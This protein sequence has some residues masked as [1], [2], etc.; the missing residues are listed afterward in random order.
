MLP[1]H[2]RA[3][4]TNEKVRLIIS[5]KYEVYIK[6]KSNV[7]CKK[8]VARQIHIPIIYISKLIHISVGKIPFCVPKVQLC[9]F[10]SKKYP[11]DSP[12]SCFFRLGIAAILKPR[13]LVKISLEVSHSV[14][15]VTNMPRVCCGEKS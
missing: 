6:C 7:K 3:D 1:I 2:N 13:L 14:L 12:T 5:F 4:T 11:Y 15:N 10:I 9:L 8:R